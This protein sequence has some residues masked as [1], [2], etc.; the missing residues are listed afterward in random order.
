MGMKRLELQPEQLRNTCDLKMFS[1][2]T[3][4]EVEPLKG[5]VGQ[6]RAVKAMEFGLQMRKQG[7]NIFIA[8]ST[9]T[10]RN[11]YARSLVE[12]FA[13]REEVP[14][15]WCYLYNM[16]KPDQPRAVSLLAGEAIQLQED[17]KNLVQSIIIE[18]PKTLNSEEYTRAKA[19]ILQELQDK[20][21][22]SLEELNTTSRKLGFSLKN[23]DKGLVTIPLGSDG[24]PLEETDFQKLDETET[25]Q[26][27]ERSREL[28]LLIMDVFKRIR[29]LEKETQD[30]IELLENQFTID[31]LEQLFS[32]LLKKYEAYSKVLT[33]L[34]DVRQDV[35]GNIKEFKIKEEKQGLERLFL[36]TERSNDFTHKYQV[37]VLV[38]NSTVKGAPVIVVTNPTYYNLAGKIEY[39][40]HLGVLTT[41]FTKIKA[42]A[43]HRANGGYLILQCKDL[44][45]N[46]FAWNAL[47]RALKTGKLHIE[48]ITEQIGIVPNSSL[49]PEPIPLSIKIILVGSYQEHQLLYHY[50]EDFHKLFRVKADFDIEMERTSEHV[51]KLAQFISD[52]RQKEELMDYSKGAVAKIVEY[53]SRL[54]DNQE[55]L[56]T[57][58]NDLVEIIYESDNWARQAD[59]QLVTEDHVQQA[60]REK[61]YRSNQYEMKLQELIEK[62]TILITVDGNKL[63]QVNGLAV[64]DMGDY[65]F[66]K[67]SRITVNTYVG[68]KGIINIEREAK[69]SGT[70]HDKGVLILSGYMG[71]KFGDKCPL[72][73]SASICFEQLYSG[74]DGDSAS[75]TELYGLLSSLAGVPIQQGIAVTGSVNQKGEIQ[76]IG[77]V[78]Q[79]IEGF[80]QIC[81]TL[82]LTGNQGVIIPQQNI[83]NLMLDEEIITAVKKGQFHIYAVNSVEEGIEILTGLPAGYPDQA[84][85]YPPETIFGRVQQRIKEIHQLAKEKDD[86]N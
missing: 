21:N 7:Y 68:Q 27:D 42:G 59:A 82:G 54:A 85:D 39:E 44:F 55:K 15:D 16:V 41:D 58:F 30:S 25:K 81:K 77:G 64:L 2:E 83:V 74:V 46:N 12:H 66:G 70:L 10:G 72:S 34:E 69:M 1:F 13:R 19:I 33:F 23:T 60:I 18:V 49:K 53:S 32:D 4:A 31:I 79:K 11:S 86:R 75:S 56:S 17:V 29:D 47:K 26:L 9:G 8:G 67:P 51:Y 52:H 50:D 6:E 43:L 62:G 22:I 65:S 78:N 28:N 20:Q 45:T 84:G 14:S 63:G 3:T 5:I 35:L 76:P 71:E 38:D 40:S 61:I 36:K 48:N 24:K 80:Y 37:N 73:F 57:R